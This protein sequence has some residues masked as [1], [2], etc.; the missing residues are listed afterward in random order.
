MLSFWSLDGSRSTPQKM[1]WRRR[2][3]VVFPL[4]EGPEMPTTSALVGVCEL[5]SVIVTFFGGV[6]VFVDG[7]EWG[8]SSL[9]VRGL[10]G[11]PY[12]RIVELAVLG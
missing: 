2:A 9:M 4:D 3:S 8:S 1:R 11:Y 12:R 10:S 5:E 6:L 7:E